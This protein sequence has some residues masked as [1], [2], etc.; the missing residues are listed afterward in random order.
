MLNRS[1]CFTFLCTLVSTFGSRFYLILKK[2]KCSLSARAVNCNNLKLIAFCYWQFQ[3]FF[4]NIQ[5]PLDTYNADELGREDLF[6]IAYHFVIKTQTHTL[7]LIPR[8]EKNLTIS[9]ITKPLSSLKPTY[10][11]T[12][13][14]LL[15]LANQHGVD[16]KG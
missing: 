1:G 13:V 9:L 2:K 8:K 12:E 4:F 14:G 10:L 16:V 11:K 3:P 15:V 5:L 7:V 6:C